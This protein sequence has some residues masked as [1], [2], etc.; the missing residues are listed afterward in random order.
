MLE[1]LFSIYP[2]NYT[3][4]DFTYAFSQQNPQFA[5]I[6]IIASL[7]FFIGYM[8]YV[9]SFKLVRREKSAPYPVWMHTFYFAHDSMGAVVFAMAAKATGGF[10]F[11][12]VSSIALII[13]NLF[14][15]YNLYKCIF[16]ER[17]EIWGALH[18]DSITVKEAFL[19]ILGQI[20]IF[21][22]VVNLFRVFMND[23]YMFKWFIFTNVLIAIV[24]GLYWEKR[25]TRIGSSYKLAIVILVGTINSFL[26]INMWSLTSDY[27]SFSNNPWFYV[28]GIVSIGFAIRN[29]V[30]LK[31]LPKKPNQLSNGIETVW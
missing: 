9:Y 5:L 10:W 22:G 8:E 18:T 1:K 21:V 3:L 17:Q 14:E 26:P 29:I 15:I 13:W 27:F 2:G 16:V 30:V 31:R 6:L 7:T 20:I 25:K 23:P 24:P 4:Q 19:R 12:T 28:L 11:F